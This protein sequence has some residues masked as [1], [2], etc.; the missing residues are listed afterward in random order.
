MLTPIHH[1][2]FLLPSPFS[3]LLLL[4]SSFYLVVSISLS[5]RFYLSVCH[6]SA[7]D[8]PFFSLVTIFISN[9]VSGS[10][11]PSLVQ[12][13]RGCQSPSRRCRWASVG[14]I[15]KKRRCGEC[16]ETTGECTGEIV[17]PT[18]D[19]V[20]TTYCTLTTLFWKW[21]NLLIVLLA[22]PF[23]KRFNIIFPICTSTSGARDCGFVVLS[24]YSWLG[25]G[26]SNRSR[27]GEEKGICCGSRQAW[28]YAGCLAVKSVRKRS[29]RE[30][31]IDVF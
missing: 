18:V 20:R 30:K 28:G 19:I 16:G 31:V 3:T 15:R 10:K 24:A 1:Y 14:V 29:Q 4:F 27:G 2:H 22:Q 6:R 7:T 13:F 21:T 12:H 25:A 23:P 17:I 9:T 26:S 5:F 8:F 11:W